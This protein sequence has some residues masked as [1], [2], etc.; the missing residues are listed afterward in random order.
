MQSLPSRPLLLSG[1]MA[2][3]KTTVA[4]HLAAKWGVPVVDLDKK[5]EGRAGMSIAALFQTAGEA[6]FRAL[7]R[8]VLL[9]ELSRHE[10][11]LCVISLGGGAL[12]DRE[13]RIKVLS[14]A[15]V[16]S[17]SA[18]VET[19]V[20]RVRAQ[21][22]NRGTRPLLA[23]AEPERAVARLLSERENAY[24]EAH[25]VVKTDGRPVA[26]I[27]DDVERLVRDD[28]VV[29]AAGEQTYR[30]LIGPGLIEPH[31]GA[32][33]GAPSGTLL[34]TDQNVNPL[35]GA[36]ARGVL[37]Q[38]GV[39]AA[40]VVLT[41]GEEHKNLGGL[42]HIFQAAFNHGLDRQATFVGLGGGVVTD[43]T[44][45]AAATWVRG[46]RWVG[47]PTTL[48]SMVDASV[49]GKTAVDFETAKNSVGAFWQPSGV[50]CDV[51][52][53]LT[54][55][56]RAYVGALS[57]VVKTALIGDPG[58]FELLE[59]QSARI[60]ARDLNLLRVIVDRCV[61]VKARIVA[62]DERESG[63]RAHLN[64]GHTLGHALESSGGYTALTHGEAVS[65][66]L[67]AALRFGEKKGHTP[68]RLTARVLALLKEL[69]LPHH[70]DRHALQESTRLLGH[71]KKRAGSKVRF[72]FA[73][74]V[75]DVFSEATDLAELQQEAVL[76]ADG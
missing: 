6:A 18:S 64:L 40:E 67:V 3:G 75:G 22:G 10:N 9:S 65:L 51:A 55:T 11:Q 39:T 17:L 19:I 49:G 68:P 2:T 24:R 74:A 5:I 42:A 27:A 47:L 16:I 61:R 28:A 45:F 7:E 4:G 32:L 31:L 72:V 30:V 33:L 1:F 29:V 57:E 48:L 14:G 59:S 54:E 34:V 41:P 38:T 37:D 52:T 62:L 66:G 26:E 69:K 50:I 8:E 46:V 63:I 35:H 56:D 70:L 36:K 23:G 43:M 73:R 13:L 15:I 76:L 58:L 71:D 53:L 21:D 44:G 25:G 60:L 20:A 12:L